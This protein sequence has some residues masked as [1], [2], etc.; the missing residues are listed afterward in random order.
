MKISTISKFVISGVLSIGFAGSALAQEVSITLAH[1][2]PAD[3]E[4][5]AAHLSATVFKNIVE[6]RSNGEMQVDIQAASA[7]GDQ[8]ER[9]ELTQTNVIQ[10]NI[11]SIGGLAQFY[12]PI[13]AVDLPF[14][15]PD[16][17][18][19]ERVFDGEFGD[20][21][22]GKL[23]EATGLRLLGVTAGDF[24]VLTNS[25]QP[26]KSPADMEGLRVRTMS[27]DSHIAMMRAL[28]AAATPVPWDE[29][30]GALETGV[31]DA[32]HNPIPI[33]AVG[34][35]QEV[36]EYATLTQH[37]YGADWWV[38][39][40][41]FM[42][43]LTPDQ[44]RIFTG[45]AEAAKVA[46]RG[47]KMALRATKFGPGFLKDA[48]LE[49]YSPSADE[50]KQFKDLAVPAV[51]DSLESEFG[52]EAVEIADALLKAVEEAEAGLYGSQ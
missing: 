6:T 30:Y 50:L 46:G 28:G 21:L 4:V 2:E 8:R 3:T 17:V 25:K 15:F 41:Q 49:V 20:M 35:L 13:N 11:A 7:M 43:G 9:L 1:E 22:A 26:V 24:Y 38:T 45:A 52:E 47:A 27:V 36:Q 32:Q 42:A 48:G 23:N 12:P 19:A 37:L 29:L 18:V 40:D 16:E 14:A 44:K 51:M 5:S 39:S 31:V 10:V 34:N 33:V